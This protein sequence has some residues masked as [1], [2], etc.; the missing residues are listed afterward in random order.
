MLA[1]RLPIREVSECTCID[2]QVL[3]T[4]QV[5]IHKGFGLSIITGLDWTSGHWWI[6]VAYSQGKCCLFVELLWRRSQLCSYDIFMALR[7]QQRFQKR[8][9]TT[10]QANVSRTDMVLYTMDNATFTNISVFKIKAKHFSFQDHKIS[11][12][13]F[14]KTVMRWVANSLAWYPAWRESHEATN[15]SVLVQWVPA[16]WESAIF[17]EC[18]SQVVLWSQTLTWKWLEVC[19]ALQDY[20][21]EETSVCPLW[22]KS[23][24]CPRGASPWTNNLSLGCK[25]I[26]TSWVC[27]FDWAIYTI[28]FTIQIFF[29]F[30]HIISQK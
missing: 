21:P 13:I 8:V 29:F 30:F 26:W 7:S 19:L 27:W 10:F 4:Y 28:G 2:W 16:C 11:T 9:Y 15:S 24:G 18:L 17:V 12:E 14:S 5:Q 1:P 22:C 3:R 6:G 20:V 25:P 23:M